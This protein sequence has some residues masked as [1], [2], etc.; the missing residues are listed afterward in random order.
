[1]RI[2]AVFVLAVSTAMPAAAQT[3]AVDDL[4]QQFGLF[5]TWAADCKQPASPA[6]PH[7]SI[8]TPS[9]GLVL[10]S[11][12]LGADYAINRYSVL[13]AKR[14]SDERLSVEVIFQ[15]GT[16]DRGTPEAGVSDPQ[17][18]AAHDVQPAGRRGRCA[19]RTA[20]RSRAAARR[21]C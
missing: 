19:S 18:H 13:S 2:V 7:V 14:L 10:E 21:R 3:A 9:A 4:F 12:D 6:N 16:E 5:G 15:P 17:R 20:S 8:T 1:M 11:H